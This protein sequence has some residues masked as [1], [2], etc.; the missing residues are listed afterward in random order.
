MHQILIPGSKKAIHWDVLTSNKSPAH[1]SKFSAT[2]ISSIHCITP[3]YMLTM[4][5]RFSSWNEGLPETD[6][7]AETVAKGMIS[8]WISHFGAPQRIPSAS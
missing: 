6:Q 7:S 8:I 5:D 4:V 1:Y 2:S 3:R